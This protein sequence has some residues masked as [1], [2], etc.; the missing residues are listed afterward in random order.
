MEI[1]RNYSIGFYCRSTGLSSAPSFSPLPCSLTH[2][3]FELALHVHLLCKSPLLRGVPTVPSL[4]CGGTETYSPTSTAPQ[5]LFFEPGRRR[6]RFDILY[7]RSR[8]L[9][10][11]FFGF[12]RFSDDRKHPLPEPPRHAR[13]QPVQFSFLPFIPPPSSGPIHPIFSHFWYFF[14]LI[15]GIESLGLLS[16][17][18]VPR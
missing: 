6:A 2:F 7:I 11:I 17:R 16:H 18:C 13:S 3:L 8:F 1:R 9:H 12:Q 15:G 5:R 4:R 10:W 14:A